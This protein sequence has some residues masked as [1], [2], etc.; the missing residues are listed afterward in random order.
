M[1]IA[2]FVVAVEEKQDLLL[3]KNT[4]VTNGHIFVG[5]TMES[6][7]L[8]R[9]VRSCQPDLV[10]VEVNNIS[11]IEQTLEAIEENLLAA[12][13]LIVNRKD[14]A[15]SNYLSKSKITFYAAKPLN[16]TVLLQ[17][18]DAALLNYQRVMDYED[19]LKKLNETLES[20]KAIEKAKWVLVE[21][22]HHTEAEAYEI[23]R[24]KSRDNRMPMREIA[25][26]ILLTT[27]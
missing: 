19:Q 17:I 14:D 25:E 15:I 16:D 11:K 3:I 18:V 7:N 22:G 27:R 26:A 1:E 8:L 24:K 13:V 9:H 12:C 4:L 5:P 6:H 20:R 2:K 23:L 10:I 21:R